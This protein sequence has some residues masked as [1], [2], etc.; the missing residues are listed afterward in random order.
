MPLSHFS[1]GCRDAA[2]LSLRLGLLD[3]LAK[4]RLPLLFDEALS[5]LDDDRAYALLQL[6]MEY[7]NAGGQCVLFTCHSREAAFLTGKE[8][9]HFELQ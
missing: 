1:A 7:C 8:F 5:R 3:T 2:H 6:L 4:E 9:T